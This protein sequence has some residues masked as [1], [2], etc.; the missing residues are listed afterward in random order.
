MQSR[1]RT[2]IVIV[3]STR[4]ASG[5]YED[6]S[7]P[8]AAEF[9]RA[10]GL[11][12]EVRVVPDA[13]IAAAVDAAFADAPAV[14]LTSGGTGVTPDDQTVEAIAPHLTKELP[15]LAW[16]FYAAS[17]AVPTAV[18]SRTI[19]GVTE[20]TFAMALPGSTGGVKDGC[21]VLEPVLPHI[22]DQ[23]EGTHGH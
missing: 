19:A 2:A 7:G 22:L 4:A 18:I 3:A 16:A 11:E 6:K 1:P 13:D 9:L 5:V 17:A 14:L 15:G 20:R 23:L 21:R 10:Q 8:I 12:V